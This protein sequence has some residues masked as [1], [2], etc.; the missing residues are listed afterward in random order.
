[1]EITRGKWA[2]GKDRPRIRMARQDL[3]QKHR[4]MIN[5]LLAELGHPEAL[6]TDESTFLDFLSQF[7]FPTLSSATAKLQ[8]LL[9]NIPEFITYSSRIEADWRLVEACELLEQEKNK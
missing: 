6:V 2:Q 3:V 4:S 8:I 1:M 9:P 5:K 7:E